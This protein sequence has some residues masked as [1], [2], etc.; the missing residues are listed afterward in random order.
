M[1]DRKVKY[2]MDKLVD[3]NILSGDG[4]VIPALSRPV[5]RRISQDVVAETVQLLDV[6]AIVLAGAIAFAFYLLAIVG[7]PSLYDGY[8]LTVVLA[9]IL[10]VFML[11]K[12]GAYSFRRLAH[13]GWQ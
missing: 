5:G 1:P 12:L 8:G 11:R 6:M 2:I 4:G 13:V 3:R 9:A 7:D 10:F